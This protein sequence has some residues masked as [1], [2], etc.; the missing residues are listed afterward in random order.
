MELSAKVAIVTGAT[1]GIGRAIALGLAEAGCSIVV[2]G[3]TETPRRQL[4]GTVYTV[5]EEVEGLG[6]AALPVGCDVRDEDSVRAMA[7]TSLDKFGRIDVLVNNAGIGSYAP[8][9]ETSLDAWERVLAVNVRGTFLCCQ[10]VLPAMIENSQG[11]VINISSLAADFVRTGGH[12][13]TEDARFIGQPYGASKAAV[14]RLSRGLAG[15]MEQHNIAVNALKP[16]KPV[17]TEGFKLQR[18]NADWSRWVGT[19]TMVQATLFLAAQDAKGLTGAVVTD[20]EIIATYG[21]DEI[22]S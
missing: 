1:R 10:A 5:A 7:Q 19:E 3:R 15:E 12:G 14:E 2:T 9:L 17:L 22:Q 18:P 16:A 11:S 20:E 6:Q 4:P 13:E 8:F 21:L